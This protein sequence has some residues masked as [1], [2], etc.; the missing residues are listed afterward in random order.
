MRP[1]VVFP[2]PVTP[3]TRRIIRVPNHSRICPTYTARP[4]KVGYHPQF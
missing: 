2:D 4:R 1:T 3:I